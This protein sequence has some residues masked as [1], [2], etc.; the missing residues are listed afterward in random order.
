MYSSWLGVLLNAPLGQFGHYLNLTEQPIQFS[1]Y[2]RAVGE[3]ALHQAAILQQSVLATQQLVKGG[4]ESLL[5]VLL[6]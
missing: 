2:G 5:D 1:V 3:V 6:Q 4:E